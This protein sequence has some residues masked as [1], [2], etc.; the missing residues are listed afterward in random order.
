MSCR[1]RSQT[2]VSAVP[3]AH[4]AGVNA[5]RPE[6]PFPYCAIAVGCAGDRCR[7]CSGDYMNQ[8][9]QGLVSIYAFPYHS[10][11]DPPRSSIIRQRD[12]SF[13]WA[14]SSVARLA[15]EQEFVIAHIRPLSNEK[16]MVT[17]PDKTRER[18]YLSSGYDAVIGVD[19]VGMGCLAGPVVVCATLFHPLFFK[20][21][22]RLLEGIRDSKLL[23]A[24]QRERYASVLKEQPYT[25]YVVVTVSPRDVD[26][27]NV[28]QAARRGMRSAVVR[29]V[30]LAST[31]SP[32]VLVDGNRD[33]PS[34][35]WPQ[36]TVIGGDRK[37]FAIACASVLAKVYRDALMVR[38]AVRYPGYGF[39]VH[40]GY[41]TELHRKRLRELGPSRF[42][43]KSFAG[44]D[45]TEKIIRAL[46]SPT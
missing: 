19:E 6:D 11:S 13:V 10:V 15:R 45:L 30:G 41:G 35:P 9:V 12:D 8:M 21:R 36:E 18:K 31:D 23:S 39:D 34:L 43:R 29:L 3:E 4:C 17:V 40:K 37:V 25:Q 28:L 22:H 33:I 5:E 14:H 2:D 27:Y 1:V 44:V 46:S 24:V 26:R 16:N 42:H 7:A 32:V 20:S 38:A